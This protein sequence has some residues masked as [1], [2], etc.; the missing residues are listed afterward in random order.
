M[1]PLTHMVLGCGATWTSQRLLA[2]LQGGAWF[3][4]MTAAT[5]SLVAIPMAYSAQA[6]D[7]LDGEGRIEVFGETWCLSPENGFER[8]RDTDRCGEMPASDAN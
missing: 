1:F 7:L 6:R 5:I 8:D 4:L 3:V 2:H